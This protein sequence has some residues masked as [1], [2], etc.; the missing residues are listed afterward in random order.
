MYEKSLLL[1]RAVKDIFYAIDAPCFPK[2]ILIKLFFQLCV[3]LFSNL[4]IVLLKIYIC[5]KN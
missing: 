1:L 2:Q 4:H 3:L 5:D